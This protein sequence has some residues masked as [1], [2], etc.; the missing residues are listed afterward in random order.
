M[1]TNSNQKPKSNFSTPKQLSKANETESESGILIT[2]SS[3]KRDSSTS[4]LISQQENEC[5]CAKLCSLIKLQLVKALQEINNRYCPSDTFKEI[6]EFEFETEKTKEEEDVSSSEVVA[7][8]LKVVKQYSMDESSSMNPPENMPPIVG[9]VDNFQIQDEAPN[10]HKYHL[11]V[12]HTT[13]AQCFFKAVQ[14]EYRLL[15]NSLPTGVWV[16]AFE[17]RLDLMR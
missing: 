9:T 1:P 12:F 8:N 6:V 16:R 7:Q 17:D 13:N 11:T 4:F 10:S 3:E 15:K 14:K 2:L 5:V